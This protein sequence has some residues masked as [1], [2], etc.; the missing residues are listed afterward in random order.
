MTGRLRLGF[1]CSHGGGSMRAILAAIESG[2]LAAQACVVIS[3][4]GDAPA[5]ALARSAGVPAVH[6]SQTRLGDAGDVDAAIAETLARHGVGLVILSGYLRKLGPQ[7][8]ARFHGRILN[9]H[10]A[11]L[12]RYGGKGMYGRRVHEA[13]IAAGEGVSGASIHVVDEHYDHGPVIARCEIPIEPG[14]T[15]ETLAGRIESREPSFFVETLRRIG[16]GAL[17]LPE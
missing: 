14:D 5:L 15:P 3:N 12:P 2:D 13:V 17:V 4:N 8:L 1:L 7:T 16:E 10:P 6:L 11:L 9:I